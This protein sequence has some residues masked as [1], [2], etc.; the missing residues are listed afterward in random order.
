[1]LACTGGAHLRQA[2]KGVCV[3]IQDAKVDKSAEV[4]RERHEAI[5]HAPAESPQS[6]SMGFGFTEHCCSSDSLLKI[7]EWSIG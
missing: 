5:L 3:S 4:V 7:Q 2:G 1:M 6:G